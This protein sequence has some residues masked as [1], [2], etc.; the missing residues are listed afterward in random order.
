MYPEEH[1]KKK[2]KRSKNYGERRKSNFTTL[3]SLFLFF[4]TRQFSLLNSLISFMILISILAGLEIGLYYA[5]SVNNTLPIILFCF[6]LF[7]YCFHIH[8]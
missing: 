8:L 6:L 1:E 7:P 2:E 5:M 4:L 3:T